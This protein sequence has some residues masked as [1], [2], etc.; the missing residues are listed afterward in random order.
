M[1]LSSGLLTE[2]GTGLFS[3]FKAKSLQLQIIYMN[4]YEY[5]FQS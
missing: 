5:V 3:F 4:I 2:S 1:I